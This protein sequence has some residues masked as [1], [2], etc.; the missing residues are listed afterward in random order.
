MHANSRKGI[1]CLPLGAPCVL[2]LAQW[3]YNAL[4]NTGADQLN[5]HCD[6]VQQHSACFTLTITAFSVLIVGSY[7]GHCHPKVSRAAANQCME[8]VHAQVRINS[9]LETGA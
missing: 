8:M 4:E 1:F 9:F 2:M 7:P 3:E 5:I 6:Y